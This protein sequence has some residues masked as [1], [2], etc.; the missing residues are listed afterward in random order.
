MRYASAIHAYAFTCH[1]LITDDDTPPTCTDFCVSICSGKFAPLPECYSA[2]LRALCGYLLQRDPERRPALDAVLARPFVRRH[3]AALAARVR[4]GGM[5]R[6]ASFE[7]MLR[8]LRLSQVR[9]R[10]L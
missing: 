10:L 5:R 4:A 7:R 6:Q 8:A 3:M 9:R 1:A 2:E